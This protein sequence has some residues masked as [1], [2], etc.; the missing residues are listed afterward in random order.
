MD[1]LITVLFKITWHL[2]YNFAINILRLPIFSSGR[3]AK[4]H[5]ACQNK[6]VQYSVNVPLLPFKITCVTHSTTTDSNSIRTNYL[7][8]KHTNSLKEINILI[9][10]L[11]LTGKS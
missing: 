3:K 10:C 5:Y 1:T 6:N 8:L 7:F 2:R 11:T 9:A 4:C